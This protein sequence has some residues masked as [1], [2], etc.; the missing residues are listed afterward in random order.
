VDTDYAC[1]AR[2][3]SGSHLTDMLALICSASVTWKTRE[4]SSAGQKIPLSLTDPVHVGNNE[5]A[6]DRSKYSNGLK[7][8]G[9]GFSPSSLLEWT[10]ALVRLFP[11]N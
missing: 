2:I 11:A 6:N 4:A 5:L 10:N 3:P 7:W 9:L 1:L 8:R